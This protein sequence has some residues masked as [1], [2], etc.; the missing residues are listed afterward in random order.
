MGPG[1]LERNQAAHA[2]R[3]QCSTRLGAHH[4]PLL[5]RPPQVFAPLCLPLLEAAFGSRKWRTLAPV[6]VLAAFQQQRTSPDQQVG[7]QQP[8]R[9]RRGSACPGAKRGAGC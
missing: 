6:A 4:R 8:G 2:Q 9:P 1:N 7:G 5:P 3:L